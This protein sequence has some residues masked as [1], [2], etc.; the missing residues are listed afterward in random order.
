MLQIL[1]QNNRLAFCKYPVVKEDQTASNEGNIG[2]K[3]VFLCLREGYISISPIYQHLENVLQTLK[4]PG[5]V[6]EFCFDQRGRTL[7]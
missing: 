6:L 1:L 3:L 2:E 5:K 7:N 4:I